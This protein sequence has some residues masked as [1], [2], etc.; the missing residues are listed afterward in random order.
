MA[1]S[2]AN[3]FVMMRVPF[4][5]FRHSYSPLTCSFRS[6][7]CRIRFVIEVLTIG[8]GPPNFLGASCSGSAFCALVVSMSTSVDLRVRRICELAL[9]LK[10]A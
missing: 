10:A 2:S 5:V 1:E 9:L 3:S 4:R 7:W 6:L 8:G